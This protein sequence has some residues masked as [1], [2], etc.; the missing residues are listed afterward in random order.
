MESP[1]TVI[2]LTFN[3]ERIIGRTLEA[4]CRISSDVHV[5]D[6]FSEDATLQIARRFCATIVQRSFE[7]YGDQRNWAIKN[8][9]APGGWQLHLDAD[10]ELTDQAISEINALDLV[11]TPIDGFMI[12][13][14]TA[15][16]GKV[17]H[18]GGLSTTW[19][20]RLFRNGKGKCEDR[21]YDQHFLPS[22]TVG[23]LR[24]SMLDH[25]TDTLS[26]WTV[27]HNR[28]A[29]LEAREVTQDTDGHGQ[30]LLPKAAGTPSQRKRYMKSIYYSRECGVLGDFLA[31]RDVRS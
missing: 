22:G 30:I 13:R 14:R 18:W 25:N 8:I 28:W 7:N 11:A 19:H 26:E 27:R 29:T 16:M 4:A 3:S 2:L 17:L 21:L 31:A 6:S 20:Y 1:I 9:P 10:E 5:V 24:G 23:Y 15:F 12:R